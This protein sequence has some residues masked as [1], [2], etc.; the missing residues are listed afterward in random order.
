[1]RKK[2][3]RRMNV[4]FGALSVSLA[5]C[6]GSQKAFVAEHGGP[7]KKYGPPPE[8]ELLEK[9]GIPPELL[10]EPVENDTVPPPE[11]VI[12]PL[13]GVPV[14]EPEPVVYGPPPGWED[15]K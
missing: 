14:P 8:P 7:A 2:F 4:L 5:G 10:D 11:P 3:L 9:Y 15:E 6:Y 1:M 12:K 13:Y